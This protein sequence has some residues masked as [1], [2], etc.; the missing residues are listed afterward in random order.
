MTRRT[1]RGETE[2]KE[3]REK[4]RERE[5]EG[6]EGRERER[7]RESARVCYVKEGERE[8]ERERQTDGQTEK[9]RGERKSAVGLGNRIVIIGL[10]IRDIL[11]RARSKLV[12]NVAAVAASVCAVRPIQQDT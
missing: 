10:H 9:P 4:E 2:N 3:E 8:R 6:C 1:D 12:R 7:E 11:Y 5:G